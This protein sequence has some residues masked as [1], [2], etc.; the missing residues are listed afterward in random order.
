MAWLRAMPGAV[1]CYTFGGMLRD[2]EDVRLARR[3]ADA[4]QQSHQVIP[5]GG[6]F[7]EQFPHYAERSVYI[8]E[9]GVDVHNA[10]DLSVCDKARQIAPVKIVGT[11]GSEIIR[12]AVMLESSAPMPGLYRPEFLEHVDAAAATCRSEEHTSE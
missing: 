3:V 8:S 11:Y 1:P 7:L 5:V 9:G 10:S 12:R 6:E 4:C 2:C